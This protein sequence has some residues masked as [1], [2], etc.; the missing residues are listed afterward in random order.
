MSV[1]QVEYSPWSLNAGRRR[2]LSR[3]LWVEDSRVNIGVCAKRWGGSGLTLCLDLLTL[4]ESEV[5]GE[6]VGA[7]AVGHGEENV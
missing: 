5:G 6:E 2:R 7:V 4:G 1:V 3:R